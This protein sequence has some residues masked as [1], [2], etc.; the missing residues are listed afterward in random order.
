MEQKIKTK[1]IVYG[2]VQEADEVLQGTVERMWV[3]DVIR[4]AKPIKMSEEK[5]QD[6]FEK[7]KARNKP[8][9]NNLGRQ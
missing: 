2:D 7:S 3:K 1:T 9:V 5:I 6:I 4:N 8:R